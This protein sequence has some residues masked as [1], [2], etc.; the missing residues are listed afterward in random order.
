MNNIDSHSA[1]NAVPK[2]SL[3]GNLDFFEEKG[4]YKELKLC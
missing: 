1:A 4:F 3:C 2:A